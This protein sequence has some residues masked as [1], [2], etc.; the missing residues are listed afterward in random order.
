[1]SDPWTEEI[2][3]TVRRAAEMGEILI[4]AIDAKRIAALYGGSL[5]SIAEALT[6]AGIRAGV[7]MQFGA[8]E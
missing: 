5:H 3:T 2:E 8:A 1:M 4:V 6:Q 7:T